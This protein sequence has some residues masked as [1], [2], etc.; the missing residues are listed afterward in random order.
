M[1]KTT[2]ASKPVAKSTQR[3]A[4][5][6]RRRRRGGVARYLIKWILVPALL[7]LAGYFLVGP[8]LMKP[9]DYEPAADRHGEPPASSGVQHEEP[10]ATG[11]GSEPKVEVTAEPAGRGRRRN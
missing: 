8:R 2:P 10:P 3:P 6:A 5:Q 9:A 11:S 7:A 1:A 4:G